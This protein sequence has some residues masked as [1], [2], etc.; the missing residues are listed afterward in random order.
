MRL[1][2]LEAS[3]WICIGAVAYTYAGYPLVL[4]ALATLSQAR[5]DLQ[6]IFHKRARRSLLAS[7]CLPQVAILLS[8]YNEEAVIESKVKNTLALDYPAERIEILIGLD[9]PSDSTADILG[10]LQTGGVRVI[11][12][13]ERQGKL[14]VL[15]DLAQQTSAEVLVI[16]DANTALERNC[17]QNLARHFADP[18][19]GAA[20]GEEIRVVAAGTDPGAESLYWKYESALKF[21]ENRLNCSL[22]GNGSVLAVRRCLFHPN[23]LSIVEDLQIPLEIRYQ[24]YRVVYDPEAVATEEIAPTFSAQF[25]RRV[26]V[27]AGNFQTLFGNIACLDPR[28]GLLAF[29]YFSHRVLRWLAP[30]FLLSAL[31]CSALLV[32]RPAFAALVGAQISFYLGALLGYWRKRR[33]KPAQR[34]VSIPF[35]FCLMNLALLLGLLRYLSG[36]Q[37]LVWA[38]TPRPLRHEAG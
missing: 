33:G 17:I 1:S 12:F 19:V 7:E 29:C 27:G 38:S 3:F 24:G 13:A 28:K 35:Q 8:A 5:S 11:H 6:F 30:I 10:R 20:S 32:R 23:K 14:K 36:R 15:C 25:A 16:T 4:F 2:G 21:L 22:G 34:L 18:S 37:T 31:L 9:A 26:R